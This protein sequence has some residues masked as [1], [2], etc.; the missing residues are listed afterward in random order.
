MAIEITQL[1]RQ[2]EFNGVQLPD[3]GPEFSPEEVRDV[4]SAQYP[5]LT[6]AVIDGPNQHADY[7]EYKFI[8]NV[9]TKG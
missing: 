2:F 1:K 9:G 6:T 3:P 4:Y 5:D 7:V 8:R